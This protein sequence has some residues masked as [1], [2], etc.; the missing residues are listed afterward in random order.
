MNFR[1]LAI[2]AVFAMC[3][4]LFSESMLVNGF[5]V[6]RNSTYIGVPRLNLI[7]E[8]AEMTYLSN[9]TMTI[10]NSMDYGA[11][12]VSIL[13]GIYFPD[14]GTDVAFTPAPAQTLPYLEWKT[15]SL[16]PGENFTITTHYKTK[17]TENMLASF[18]APMIKYVEDDS[19]YVPSRVTI[20][21]PSKVAPGKEIKIQA[22][23]EKGR[24]VAGMTLL[25][26]GPDGYL[27]E[28]VTGP[29][30]YATTVIGKKG[31]YTIASKT[32]MVTGNTLIESADLEPPVTASSTAPG[33]GAGGFRLEDILSIIGGIVLVSVLLSVIFFMAKKGGSAPAQDEAKEEKKHEEAPQEIVIDEGKMFA[34]NR[35]QASAFAGS[36]S[37]TVVEESGQEAVS[38]EATK[39]MIEDR[40]RKKENEVEEAA[41]AAAQESSDDDDEGG[42]E[43]ASEE[44]GEG[45]GEEPE[46][47]P[48][49]EEQGAE[50]QEEEQEEEAEEPKPVS[51]KSPAKKI[52]KP[53]KKQ[54]AAKLLSAKPSATARKEALKRAVKRLEEL[55]AKRKR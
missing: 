3:G 14:D 44:A 37:T 15:R 9:V 16:K 7:T 28:I 35:T 34:A 4:S 1:L 5:T 27:S 24:P 41:A 12:N 20:N 8:V 6:S 55:K 39:R 18:P 53:A 2:I 38:E 32:A 11:L 21:A 29:D 36:E 22:L 17:I 23:D 54:P 48:A 26:G 10:T 19:G 43:P 46:D 51:K 31:K 30:G 13:D 49:G 45:K 47:E 33:N 42:A 40:L 52:Q 25:I 50:E